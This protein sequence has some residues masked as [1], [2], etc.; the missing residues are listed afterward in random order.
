MERIC[1]IPVSH[2]SPLVLC[3]LCRRC[4][5]SDLAA[6]SPLAHGVTSASLIHCL[7]AMAVRVDDKGC[8][9][10]VAIVGPQ[11][12][13]AVIGPAMGERGYMK[14][15]DRVLIIGVKGQMKPLIQADSLF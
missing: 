11:A 8:I 6:P 5:R 4:V 2:I 3:V 13:R 12:R 1:D 7:Q 10:M 15:I 14:L 9:I